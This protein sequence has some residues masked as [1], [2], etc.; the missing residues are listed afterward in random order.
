M[1]PVAVISRPELCMVSITDGKE[2]LAANVGVIRNMLP[3]RK[4]VGSLPIIS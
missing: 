4:G 1:R 3:A 2:L